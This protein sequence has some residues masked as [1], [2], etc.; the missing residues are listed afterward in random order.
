MF[1][2]STPITTTMETALVIAT[3]ISIEATRTN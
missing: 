2:E 3:T 1:T